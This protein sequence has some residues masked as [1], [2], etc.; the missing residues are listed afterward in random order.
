MTI[1]NLLC[2]LQLSNALF[3]P[4]MWGVDY[5]GKQETPI[6]NAQVKF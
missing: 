2:L 5:E 4:Y 6:E 1:C 3:S